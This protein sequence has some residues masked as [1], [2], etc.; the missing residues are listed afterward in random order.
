MFG[1]LSTLAGGLGFLL[2]LTAWGQWVTLARIWLPLTGRMPWRVMTFLEDA[3]RR[4][5]LR[6]AGAF[7]QFRHAQLQDHFARP[8]DEGDRQCARLPGVQDQ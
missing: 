7:H 1:L 2:S 4:G 3:H 5:V 6:Q 8:K